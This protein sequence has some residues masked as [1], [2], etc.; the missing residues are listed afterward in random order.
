[1]ISEL[2]VGMCNS[3]QTKRVDMNYSFM[4]M[5]ILKIEWN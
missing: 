5:A 1:M 3:I 4:L 2:V